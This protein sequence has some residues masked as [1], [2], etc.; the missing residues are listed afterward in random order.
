[1]TR[2]SY[3]SIDGVR[4]RKPWAILVVLSRIAKL[5]C[6]LGAT[7]VGI[8]SLLPKQKADETLRAEVERVEQETA[9]LR[10]LAAKERKT[11]ER[12][13]YDREYLEIV[14]RD[15]LDV[16]SPGEMIIRFKENGEIQ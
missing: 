6:L 1:M 3:N 13:R 10:E 14:A 15:R 7:A 5:I 4:R 2:S 11:T 12:L 8:G 16:Y 9:K